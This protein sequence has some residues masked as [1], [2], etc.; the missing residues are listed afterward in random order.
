[1]LRPLLQ[2]YCAHAESLVCDRP[3]VSC[4]EARVRHTISMCMLR[5]R[6]QQR[7]ASCHQLGC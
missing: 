5:G 6:L 2:L 3:K 7:T 4:S 1:M